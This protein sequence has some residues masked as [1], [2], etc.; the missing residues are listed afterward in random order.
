MAIIYTDQKSRKKKH[1]SRKA[2]A[3]KESWKELLDKYPTKELGP[4]KQKT[5]S[6]KIPR[7]TIRHPSLDTGYGQTPM[8]PEKVYTG[9]EMIGTSQLHKSNE[10]PVFRKEDVIDIAKMRR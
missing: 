1:K 10:I 3:L 7:E 6:L 2:E 8:P 5:Y 9:T 4:V